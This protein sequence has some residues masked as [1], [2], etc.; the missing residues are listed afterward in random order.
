[1]A[2]SPNRGYVF[3]HYSYSPSPNYNPGAPSDSVPSYNRLARFTVPDSSLVADRNSELVLINQ[4]D[5]HLWHSGGAL[6][7]DT[8]GYLYVSCGDEGGNN[9]PYAHGGKI[10]LGFFCGVLRID[11]DQKASRS[12]P[13][14][15][16]PQSAATPP[17][18]WPA[19]YTQNYTIPNDNPWLD[20]AGS[21]LEEFYAVG[22]RNPHR[23]TYD[24]QSNRIWLGDVGQS[25]REEVSI[26][27]KGGNYQW[28]YT[29]GAATGP[30]ARPNPIVGLEKPPV[31]D[32]PHT[33]GYTC[34]IGGYV[35]RGTQFAAYLQGKYVFGDNGTARIR[36][37]SYDGTSAPQVIELTTIPHGGGE[38]TGMSTFGLDHN[39][40]LLMCCA[41][42]GVKIYKLTKATTGVEPPALLSQTGAFGSDPSTLTPSSALIPYTVNA[43]LWSDN[44][45]KTRWMSVPNDGAPFT[46][47]ETVGFA[48]TGA[49]SFPIGTVFVKHFE[50]PIDQTNPAVRKRLETRFLVH[51]ND[52]SYYGLTYKW[53]ADNSDADLLPAGLNETIPIT[54]ATGTSSQTW[55]YPSRQDCI[56]CHN[57]NAGSV[58]GAR[59][60]ELNGLFEYPAPGMADN[61]LRALSHIGLFT[62][63]PIESSIPTLPK[64][65]SI[66][67]SSASLELRVR[68]YLDSNCAHCH[69]PNGV[70]ANFDA[71]LETPLVFQG[72]IGGALN[73]PLGIVGAQL[74]VP[75]DVNRSMLRHRD[76]LLGTNQMPT[77]AR[78][79]VDADYIS[80][81][82]QWINS[83]PLT[84]SSSIF[85]TQMPGFPGDDSDYELGMKF[86]A[87]QPGRIT[88]IRYYRPAA[89]SGAHIGRLWTSGGALLAIVNFSGESAAGWQLATLTTPVLIAANTT[90]VVSVNNNTHYAFLDQGLA[91]AVTRGPLNSVADG[92]NGVVNDTPGIFPT[93]TYH[94]ANYFREVLFTPLTAFEQWKVASSIPIGAAATSDDDRDGIPLLIEYALGLDA[95]S[96]HRLG[97][98]TA[99][100]QTNGALALVHRRL[101]AAKDI[102]YTAEVSNDLV[103]WYSGP[104]YTTILSIIGNAREEQWTVGSLLTPDASGRQFMRLRVTRP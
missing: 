44:A 73:D 58:L 98:P 2:G 63:A 62:T 102:A 52:G 68:S 16:Q 10:N 8:D 5:R 53:R 71:R 94:S 1:M 12:H 48:N 82:S 92:V 57:P 77:L 15:R 40:E 69:R 29:E 18:G 19:T 51:A 88:G 4:Y 17:N 13:I 99:T 91:A 80:V 76:S 47:G 14:R 20:A 61:Q 100:I 74:I 43:P 21:V 28:S 56:V 22:F 6:C 38:T 37:L 75:R 84:Y 86:R 24:A 93:S 25:T 33:N 85:T 46:A 59:T 66:H 39:N 7:F 34:V 104:G 70:R 72:L 79:V 95:N 101:P 49:W 89:E 11:V 36:A 27:E 32:Y 54:T 41:G 64:S 90:Y 45:V 97:L 9:D 23:M 26:I 31:F 78:N 55:S 50:L 103:N 83:L 42:P 87:S 81:L 30:N 60:C 96:P 67:D 35:Y 65:A 3:I